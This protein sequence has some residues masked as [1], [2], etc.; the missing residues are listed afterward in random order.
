M[1]SDVDNHSRV[2][3]TTADLSVGLPSGRLS[4]FIQCDHRKAHNQLLEDNHVNLLPEGKI[5]NGKW[6]R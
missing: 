2:L 1:H 6:C 5:S 4:L 3:S